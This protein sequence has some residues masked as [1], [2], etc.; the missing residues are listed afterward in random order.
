[1]P[2]ALITVGFKIF[3]YIVALVHTAP[4]VD[5]YHYYRRRTLAKVP[6]HF[7][8]LFPFFDKPELRDF[9]HH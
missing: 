2:L 6:R 3:P 1:M 7:S 9:Y 4:Y 5:L 8:F